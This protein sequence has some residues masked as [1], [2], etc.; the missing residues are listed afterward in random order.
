MLHIW[1]PWSCLNPEGHPFVRTT[2][3]LVAN[4][5]IPMYTS[6]CLAAVCFWIIELALLTMHGE[7]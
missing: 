1:R 3:V 5:A 2:V 4:I 7:W 6:D